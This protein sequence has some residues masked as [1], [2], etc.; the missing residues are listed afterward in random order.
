ME[1]DYSSRNQNCYSCGNL[2]FNPLKSAPGHNHE[3][4]I[5]QPELCFI[6][7]VG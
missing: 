2:T 1:V 4:T 5:F 7:A 6:K 3:N